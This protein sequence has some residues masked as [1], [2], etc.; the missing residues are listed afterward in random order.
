VKPLNCPNCS[1][2]GSG[3]GWS[4]Q[5][6]APSRG[7]SRTARQKTR[8]IAER[9][10]SRSAKTYGL[11]AHGIRSCEKINNFTQ[12][13]QGAKTRKEQHL[14]FLCAFYSLRLCVK[15]FCS[16][17]NYFTAS[18]AVGKPWT[19]FCH[20]YA[21]CIRSLF[22][23]VCF[24]A[25]ERVACSADLFPRS[26]AFVELGRTADLQTRSALR[27]LADRERNGRDDPQLQSR[28]SSLG[29]NPR[30]AQKN[31]KET[32]TLSLLETGLPFFV[33]GLNFHVFSVLTAFYPDPCPIP[34]RPRRP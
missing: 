28:G 9:G 10:T 4:S 33:A 13:R 32:S 2:P 30:A 20:H 14:C 18:T 15:C 16:S 1:P 3:G 27:P 5:R 6:S 31:L 19:T 26:A 8:V 11:V 25:D 12:R 34:F 23:M 22:P 24:A 7:G 17:G 29:D 21:A